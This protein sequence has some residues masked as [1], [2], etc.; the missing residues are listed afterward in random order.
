MST[1]IAVPRTAPIAIAPK[2]P[3]ARFPPSRQGSVH[4]HGHNFDSYGSGFNSPDSGSVLSLNTPPCEACRNRRSE[5]VMGEDTEEHCVACQY[6]GTECSLVESSG[7]S[8]PLGARKRKL[9]GG[10]GAEEGRSKR[11]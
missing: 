7:S 5:C 3:A 11:R 1:S 6:S 10:D 2:P 9:N 4:H 8:S